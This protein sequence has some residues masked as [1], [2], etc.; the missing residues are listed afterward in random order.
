MFSNIPFE[1][2]RAGLNFKYK[3]EILVQSMPGGGAP[4]S[5]SFYKNPQFFISTDRSKVLNFAAV[6]SKA[7][8]VLFSYTNSSGGEKT[9]IKQFLCK[10]TVGNYRI[11]TIND[12][13][14]LD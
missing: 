12:E 8:D 5:P 7:F 2:G 13:T 14:I 3:Q 10:A 6:K 11:S 4:N 9:S 1:I